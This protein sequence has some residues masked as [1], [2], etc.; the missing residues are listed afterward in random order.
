MN[1]RDE[2]RVENAAAGNR[3]GL[4]R[5]GSPASLNR[6]GRIKGARGSSCWAGEKHREGVLS[7]LPGNY[8]LRYPGI[9]VELHLFFA[10]RSGRVFQKTHK[11]PAVMRGRFK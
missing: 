11:T 1:G 9:F 5:K 4:G 6:G 2:T 3:T 10:G 7:Y 8:L